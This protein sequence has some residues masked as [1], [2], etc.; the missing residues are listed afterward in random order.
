MQVIV[1]RLLR[2]NEMKMFYSLKPQPDRLIFFRPKTSGSPPDFLKKHKAQKR[3]RTMF[4]CAAHCLPDWRATRHLL[5]N[6][7]RRA[8]THRS[9]AGPARQTDRQKFA[10]GMTL[11]RFVCCGVSRR[12]HLPM[13]PIFMGDALFLTPSPAVAT[14]KWVFA[15]LPNVLSCLAT[16]L[17]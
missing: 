9:D 2:F 5:V 12:E 6:A 4:G 8:H 17:C 11:F 13:L 3:V 15:Q 16:R 10:S 7:K 14:V 1:L